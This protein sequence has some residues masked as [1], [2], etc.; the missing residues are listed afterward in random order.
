MASVYLAYADDFEQRSRVW[1]AEEPPL[2]EHEQI[3][4]W[5]HYLALVLHQLPQRDMAEKLLEAL[6]AW[7]ANAA[8]KF[9]APRGQLAAEGLLRL[10]A[11]LELVTEL[12]Q[13]AEVYVIETQAAEGD[14][15]RVTARLPAEGR[16]N[17]LAHSALALGQY[18]LARNPVFFRELPVHVLALRKF[19]VDVMPFSE[20]DS[21]A[22]APAY[23]FNAAL[24]LYDSLSGRGGTTQ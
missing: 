22:E 18:F 2:P 8:P 6:A 5:D 3:W 1:V 12:E 23:A 20:A 21:V 24:R 9:F 15:P 17:R 13:R 4:V 11:G 16:P 14:W 10:D 7:A 19:Y